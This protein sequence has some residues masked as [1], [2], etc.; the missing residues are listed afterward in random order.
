MSCEAALP[1][2]RRRIRLIKSSY[3]PRTKPKSRVA[4]NPLGDGKRPGR[5]QRMS[6]RGRVLTIA[7]PALGAIVL[8]VLTPLL[9]SLGQSIET[10]AQTIGLPEYDPK[11]PFE[12]TRARDQQPEL[13]FG[14]THLVTSPAE[15]AAILSYDFPSSAIPMGTRSDTF[16][17]SGR[18]DGEVSVVNIEPVDLR[19]G[20]GLVQSCI[21]VPTGGGGGTT[22]QTLLV[23]LDNGI[24]R[25]S[26][27][28]NTQPFF[29]SHTLTV[30]R[31][32]RVL[33]TLQASFTRQVDASWLYRMTVLPSGP[34]SKTKS[35]Y[36]DRQG[37]FYETAASVKAANRFSIT[38]R[39]NSCN[40][41]YGPDSTHQLARLNG[42]HQLPPA[43]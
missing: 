20:S 25:G 38:G 5:W 15:N 3:T 33:L 43:S 13:Y 9:T 4:P 10:R 34:N 6:R 2:R 12:L 27:P 21:V 24:T 30:T 17:L 28:A 29:N 18:S 31:Q 37:R 32:D 8:T 19:Y 42:V 7:V 41:V 23:D 1:E 36:L 39:R 22:Q 16:V 11:Q 40:L 35:L 26:D 14:L